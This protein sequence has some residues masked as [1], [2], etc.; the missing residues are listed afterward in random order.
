[1]IDIMPIEY[2]VKKDAVLFGSLQIKMGTV[3]S[4]KNPDTSDNTQ[5]LLSRN[6]VSILITQDELNQ[7]FERK[8]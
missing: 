7:Y 8:I 4:Y 6:N 3:W 2:V 5:L 1:M